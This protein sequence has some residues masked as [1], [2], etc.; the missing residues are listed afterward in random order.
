MT[1]SAL[2]MQNEALV[3]AASPQVAIDTSRRP[4]IFLRLFRF[5]VTVVWWLF[6][7]SCLL[8]GLAVVAAIPV[9]QLL[10]FGYLLEL[11]GRVARTGR[12]RDAFTAV[13]IAARVGATL[14]M[15]WLFL[16]PAKFLAG[17]HRDALLIDTASSTTK[18]LGRW[19]TILFV[20]AFVQ[21]VLAIARGGKLRYFFRPLQNLRWLITSLRDGAI[22]SNIWSTTSNFVKQLQLGRIF[23]LGFRGFLGTG[24][25]LVIPSGLLVLGR[26]NPFLGYVGGF[27]LAVV[28]LYVPFLQAHFAAENRLSAFLEYRKM[29]DYFSRAP[30]AFLI[31]LLLTLTLALPLYLLK[32]EIVMRDILWLLVLVFIVTILPAKLLAGWTYHRAAH[33]SAHAHW[34]IRMSCRLL[35]PV[36]SITYVIVVFFSQYTVWSGA[37]GMFEH[38][39]FLLPVPF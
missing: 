7:L 23:S 6:G 26:T 30:I 27:L 24:L 12:L 11:M 35:L 29:R 4:G 15:A 34:S 20:I 28:V 39:A 36:I 8:L 37:L 16:Q 17:L 18:N 19:A 31:T 21:I 13:P 25:W 14:A 1:A 9:I 32:I 10:T 38:H 33:K 3:E 2:G 5:F 22:A